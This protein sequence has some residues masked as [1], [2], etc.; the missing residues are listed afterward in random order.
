MLGII[1]GISSVI[2][3]MTL[4]EIG[5]ASIGKDVEGT[6]G[7]RRV[8]I[9]LDWN[10]DIRRTDFLNHSDLRKI[11]NVFSKEVEYLS[12]VSWG[13]SGKAK[14]NKEFGNVHIQGVNEEYKHIGKVNIIKG[15]FLNKSD[16]TGRR[17]V[18]TINKKLA[19]KLFKRTSVVGETLKIERGDLEQNYTI[20]GVYEEPPSLFDKLNNSN[21]TTLYAPLSIIEYDDEYDSIDIQLSKNC[22]IEETS[23]KI[24][25]FISRIKGKEN[26]YRSESAK[27]QMNMIDGILNKISLGIG[28]VAAISLLVGGIGVM[29][30]MLVSVTERTREIGIRKALGAKRKDILLQFLVESMIISGV[31]GLIGVTLGLGVSNIAAIILKVTPSVPIRYILISVSFSA[32]VGIFFGIYPANK[33]AKLDPIEALRYE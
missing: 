8:A 31:G 25:R 4:G 27:G 30:I 23:S 26:L 7:T 20:V 13:G 15:R 1:I 24:L 16:V 2:T 12:P 21:R 33:A 9:Y 28:A 18:A 10:D 5:K 3:I 6:I 19:L 14:K 11:R 17:Y 29:N 22:D 32:I